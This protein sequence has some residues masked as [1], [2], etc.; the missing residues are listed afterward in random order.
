MANVCLAREPQRGY[1]GFIEWDN[2]VGKI[3]NHVVN[4]KKIGAATWF[5]GFATTHGFQFNNH[6]FLGLGA[7]ASLSFYRESFGIM[8]PF[9]IDFRYDVK[10]GKFSPYADMK[11][12]FDTEGGYFSPTIGYRCNCGAKA[13]INFGL[14]LTLR[15]F[16][17]DY[18]TETT[19]KGSSVTSVT[20]KK[21]NLF[22]P[23]VTFR[24][25]V[26]F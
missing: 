23:F 13:N 22:D 18:I 2:T 6:C 17:D 8:W 9:Y 14:G 1:R 15:R 21:T 12:G 25:G 26:D 24:V 10:F 11:I 3:D 20:Y 19:N 7:M 4:G 16:I 5:T